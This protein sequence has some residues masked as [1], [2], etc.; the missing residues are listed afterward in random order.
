MNE[1]LPIVLIEGLL[2]LGGALLFGWW[3]LRS[4]RRDQ[5]KAAAERAARQAADATADAT[6]AGATE[7]AATAQRGQ[8][9]V[10]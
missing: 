4:I 8:R 6:A 1:N 3:Q 7:A 2:V 5:Q 10:A 9:D